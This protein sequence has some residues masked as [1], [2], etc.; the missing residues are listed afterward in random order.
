MSTDTKT[1][2]E[3]LDRLNEARRQVGLLPIGSRL[4]R[5][6]QRTRRRNQKRRS[7]A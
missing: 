1:P 2:G 4:R 6:A 7:R 3:L 5:R